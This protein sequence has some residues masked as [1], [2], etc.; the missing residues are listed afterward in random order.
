MTNTK[1]DFSYLYINKKRLT[2]ENLYR[3][4]VIED[5]KGIK[6]DKKKF[7]NEFKDLVNIR[8][9]DGTFMLYNYKTGTTDKVKDLELEIIIKFIIDEID[10]RLWTLSISSIVKEI[11]KREVDIMTE[12]P[13][14]NNYIF[15]NNG[16]YD[17]N[18]M[19]IIEYSP[20]I[21]VTSKVANNY[22]KNA[23]CPK[24]IKFIEESMCG[25]NELINVIQE[26]LGY[27]LIDSNKAQKFF[28]LY[29]IGSNGKSVLADV[30]IDMVG[31]NN[32]SSVSLKQMNENFTIANIVGKKVNV[33]TENDGDFETERLKALTSGDTI[34]INQKYKEPFEYKPTS[35]LVFI[36]NTLPNTPDNS[37]GFY[38]RLKIIPFENMISDEQKDVNLLDKLRKER[39]GILK[40]AIDG[41]HRLIKN[42]YIFSESKAINKIT[43][44][45]KS[46]QDP[47]RMYFSE[48]IQ[49]DKG[50]KIQ[51]KE[52]IDDYRDWCNVNSVATKGTDSTSKFWKEF[53][54][55]AELE[56]IE[57]EEVKSSGIRYIKNIG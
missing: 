18:S 37:H 24:F 11:L 42:N 33:S 36:S 25:D 12:I 48:N 5:E 10:R 28:L 49:Y 44:E 53:R 55:V 20:N 32:V 1:K 56:K 38:R 30:I 35:K 3:K 39:E 51:K 16:I 8:C 27:I 57:I 31:V 26:M 4:T 41:M 19:S 29:G 50:G 9:I 40:W 54:R 43:K 6:L 45:Y 46:S 34:T 21:I 22:N 47:V 14:Y 7:V 23:K 15:F 2:I 52:L 13:V 17:I